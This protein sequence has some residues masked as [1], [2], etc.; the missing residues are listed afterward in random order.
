MHFIE[1]LTVQR[2]CT[3]SERSR[4]L[5]PFQH[6][7]DAVMFP[8]PKKISLAL[9]SFLVLDCLMS[10]IAVQVVRTQ[11]HIKLTIKY[12]LLHFVSQFITSD[13]L[14]FPHSRAC[15]VK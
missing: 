11:W 4:F 12:K 2:T 13:V 7:S 14:S 5:G 3:E 9:D 6:M 15:S 10:L 1:Q 8:Q